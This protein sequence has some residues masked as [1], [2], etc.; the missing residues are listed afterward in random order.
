[1]SES[2]RKRLVYG[3]LVAAVIW[4]VMNNPFAEQTPPP[5]ANSTDA[6][7][8][9]PMDSTAEPAKVAD[10]ARTDSVLQWKH[11]PF[12]RARKARVGRAKGVGL[13]L[14]AISITNEKSM[15]MINGKIVW[16][17]EQIDGWAVVDIQEERV[18]LKKGSKNKELKLKR[19]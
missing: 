19:R 4:G 14:S 16:S 13:A 6:L 8:S 2:L 9:E 10:V 5:V 17:G 15:A 1:L 12:I 3:V 11:D 18:I 7:L